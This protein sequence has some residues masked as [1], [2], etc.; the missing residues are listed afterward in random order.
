MDR[1]RFLAAGAGAA[2]GTALPAGSSRSDRLERIGLQL[3]TV[4]GEME[5]DLDGTLDAVA[6]VGYQ[7][8]QFAG[9]FGRSPTQ[10][11]AALDAAG[12][13]APGAHIPYDALGERWDA[14]LDGAHVMGHRYLLVAWIPAGERSTLDGY[15]RIAARFER[16]AERARTAG[17]LF[18]YH[19]HDYEFA[20]MEGQVPYD[21]LL[22]EASYLVKMEMD[23]FWITRGGG[24]PLAYFRAYPGRFHTVHVKD[25]DAR[26]RMVDV[27]KG[28]IPF[29]RI[30][31]M[32]E[33]AGL[34]HYFVEH[35]TPEQPLDSIRASYQYLRRLEF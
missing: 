35:D 9:Y 31:A 16:A 14:T 23:L 24:D 21:V 20:R 4:R 2:L 29:G 30:F 19:N 25:M 12:L 8:V 15:R 1:R 3:Y 26:G 17:I 28:T 6:R 22:A 33:Q 10:V 13:T 34:R 32:R 7:E 18:A 5:R 27:G 11:R